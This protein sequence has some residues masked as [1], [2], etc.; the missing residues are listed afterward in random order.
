MIDGNAEII[1]PWNALPEGFQLWMMHRAGMPERY[2]CLA[3]THSE[4]G[5]IYEWLMRTEKSDIPRAGEDEVARQI[6]AELR[7]MVQAPFMR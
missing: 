2:S 6:D 5:L 7:A 1:P 3:E 4:T